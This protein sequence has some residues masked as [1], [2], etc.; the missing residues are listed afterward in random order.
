MGTAVRRVAALMPARVIHC[1]E[2]ARYSND[3]YVY[4]GRPS[5]WGNP[6][7][8]V[9]AGIRVPS[10]AEAIRRYREWFLA[11]EQAQFR[12]DAVRELADKILGCW[13]APKPCHVD[14]IAE[15]VNRAIAQ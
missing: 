3:E 6:F 10:R 15:F 11:P 5:K 14:I 13:C 8:P 9:G 2:A 12:R 4:C 1:R 7:G